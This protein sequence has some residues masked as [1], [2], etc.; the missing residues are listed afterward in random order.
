MLWWAWLGTFLRAE[1]PRIAAFLG[2]RRGGSILSGGCLETLLLLKVQVVPHG[3]SDLPTRW[4]CHHLVSVVVVRAR[5]WFKGRLLSL[6]EKLQRLVHG[7][8]LT[9]FTDK[10]LWGVRPRTRCAERLKLGPG[11]RSETEVR[12]GAHQR[13]IDLVVGA[14]ARLLSLLFCVGVSGAG[15]AAEGKTFTVHVVYVVLVL[16]VVVS[17]TGCEVPLLK[18]EVFQP[19]CKRVVQVVFLLLVDAIAAWTGA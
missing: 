4:L 10:F 19:A 18:L 5:A 13:V 16:E 9:F 11:A 7:L 2:Q 8:F 17:G 15:F 6:W 14:C 1:A 3:T 12:G